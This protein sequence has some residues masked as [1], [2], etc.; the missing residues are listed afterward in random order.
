MP[1]I[2]TYCHLCGKNMGWTRSLLVPVLP[3]PICTPC[4]EGTR[5]NYNDQRLGLS[6]PLPTFSVEFEIHTLSPAARNRALK[7]LQYHYVR[8]DDASVS[9]EYKS[10]I[11][12]SL[13]A[14]RSH[15]PILD[16]LRELVDDRC[17]THVHIG[18]PHHLTES[19]IAVSHAAFGPLQYHLQSHQSETEQFWGR[20]FCQY[21]QPEIRTYY[22]WVRLLTSYP[23]LEYRL[24]RF[25]TGW[26][27]VEAVRF[28]RK[29]TFYLEQTLAALDARHDPLG[30]GEL[31]YHLRQTPECM[32]DRLLSFYREALGNYHRQFHRQG[33]GALSYLPAAS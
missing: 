29:V 8:T 9:D 27:Y 10:P 15:L 17:G 1:F 7:L 6:S 14:F 25:R 3:F 11:Y 22:P 13:S 24:P 12:R 16:G 23:T 5:F 30:R 32:G 28:C 31:S 26:Q 19:L 33:P 4:L 2:D 21:A 20:F 18:F